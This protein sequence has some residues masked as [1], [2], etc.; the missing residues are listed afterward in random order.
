MLKLFIN[1]GTEEVLRI[2]ILNSKIVCLPY[3]FLNMVGPVY[4]YST[5]MCNINVLDTLFTGGKGIMSALMEV[6]YWKSH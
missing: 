5:T 4:R 6:I 2:I 1:K 3:L